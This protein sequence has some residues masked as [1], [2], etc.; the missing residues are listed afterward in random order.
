MKLVDTSVVADIDRGGV[1]NRVAKLDEEGPHAISAVT[2]TELTHGVHRRNDPG[3]EGHDQ[4]LLALDRLLAR[5][6]VLPVTRAVAS[7]AAD[8]IHELRVGGT[9]LNDLHDVYI[10]ATGR[11]EQLHVLTG[12]ASDFDR[13]PDISVV[14]WDEY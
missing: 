12:N 14:D 2:V 7:A 4:A 11:T 3:T 9:S 5:F 1:G 10:A 6:D 8:I 13:I